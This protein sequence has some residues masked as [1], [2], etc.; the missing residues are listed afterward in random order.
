[1]KAAI[2]L[3]EI[4]SAVTGDKGIW[5]K[6]WRGMHNHQ[7]AHLEYRRIPRKRN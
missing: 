7:Y 3:K 6:Q 1:M 2:T 5:P 4:Y